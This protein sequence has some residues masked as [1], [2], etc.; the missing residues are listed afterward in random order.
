L[1][2][3]ELKL[4]VYVPVKKAERQNQLNNHILSLTVY[5]FLLKIRDKLNVKVTKSA[6][7]GEMLWKSLLQGLVWLLAG[8]MAR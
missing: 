5:Q 7:G 8:F 4:V 3:L 1:N 6:T 2:T